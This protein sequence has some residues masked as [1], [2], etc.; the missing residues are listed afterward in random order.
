MYVSHRTSRILSDTSTRQFG[1]TQSI[2]F[3]KRHFVYSQHPLLEEC[4]AQNG[5]R[6]AK[7]VFTQRHLSGFCEE[8]SDVDK[9]EALLSRA[10]TAAP[11]A[12][13]DSVILHTSTASWSLDGCRDKIKQPAARFEMG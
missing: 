7:L 1:A 5:K 2:N 6:S 3:Q 13:A 11:A 9:S 8:K 4:V 10:C 12:P